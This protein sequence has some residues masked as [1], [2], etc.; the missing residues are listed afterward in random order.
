MGD[1]SEGGPCALIDFVNEYEVR[2][3]L[4]MVLLR[5]ML[6]NAVL[7]LI[8][9]TTCW[10]IWNFILVPKFSAPVLSPW[11]ILGLLYGLRL[12]ITS[13]KKKE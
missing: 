1:D 4:L 12:G 11:E 5:S 9:A 8:D 7:L 13:F 2:K 10:T 3:N 6:I